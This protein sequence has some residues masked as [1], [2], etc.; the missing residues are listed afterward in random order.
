M[1]RKNC[2]ELFSRYGKEFGVI[3]DKSDYR[4]PVLVFDLRR[5]CAARAC[6]VWVCL[7]VKNLFLL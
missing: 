6:G 3:L 5:I 7:S 2:E 1:Q 4:G